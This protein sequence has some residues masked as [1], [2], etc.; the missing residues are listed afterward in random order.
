MK[1]IAIIGGGAAGF[2][3]AANLG[4][5]WGQK[6]VIFEQSLHPMGKIRISG[7]GRCNVTHACFDPAELVEFYPRG[8]KELLSVFHKFQPGD[9]MEWF[10]S[11]GV[12]LKIENDNRVFPV[13][14]DSISVI[15][16][17]MN[18]AEKN[19]VE[20]RFGEGVQQISRSED[21]FLLQTKSGQYRFKK[22]VFTPGSSPK[23]M[24]I[25]RRLGHNIVPL[26]P[27]LFTFNIKDKRIDGLM[28]IG[29]EQAEISI[30]ELKLSAEGPLLITHWGL[31]GPGIL[32]L[33]ALAAVE[34]HRLNYNF[35]IKVNFIQQ[36]YNE[37]VDL[38]NRFKLEH[39]KKSVHKFNP[40]PFPKRFWQGLLSQADISPGLTYSNFNKF[41]LHQLATELTEAIYQVKGKSTYKDE[42]VTAGG[43]ELK[44]VNF[45]TMESKL[46][47]G[48]Y[49][50]GE[51]LNIDAVT[52]GFNFQA[53]WSEAHLIATAI[54]NL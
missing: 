2:F 12:A 1:E 4:M 34:L 23:A 14:D 6:T 13:S 8:K 36:Q 22:V 5:K 46:I 45:K 52:G 47:P 20:F 15:E 42:F 29:F 41:Q 16:C 39:S 7:G 25:I 38:L 10:E 51:V 43:V 9:T 50:A 37:S 53:C 44:E 49:L 27:S 28:G 30:P 18:Q 17:L 48:L 11:R 31:S 33:S 24:E 3:T 54:N 21:G 35:K 40:F 19:G 26:V 32:K